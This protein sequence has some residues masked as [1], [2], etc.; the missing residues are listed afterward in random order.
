MYVR[1]H[2]RVRT[3]VPSQVHSFVRAYVHALTHALLRTYARV[4]QVTVEVFV[5]AKAIKPGDVL[6]VEKER[7]GK[8]IVAAEPAAAQKDAAEGGS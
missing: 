6:T 1:A 4:R 3:R 5:S 7:E 8:E 2:S